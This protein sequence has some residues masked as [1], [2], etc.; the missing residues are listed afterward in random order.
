[1]R[2]MTVRRPSTCRIV[3]AIGLLALALVIP[4]SLAAPSIGGGVVEGH[5]RP[6]AGV[7]LVIWMRR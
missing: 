3:G 2:T 1:M 6:V 5:D 4:A 7:A